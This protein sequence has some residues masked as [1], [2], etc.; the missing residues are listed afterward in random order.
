MKFYVEGRN[1]SVVEMYL[2]NAATGD[3]AAEKVAARFPGLKIA[4]VSH[5][6]PIDL[7]PGRNIEHAR[8]LDPPVSGKAA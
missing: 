5:A 6:S 3:A 1:G 7:P 4:Y 2:I 8:D